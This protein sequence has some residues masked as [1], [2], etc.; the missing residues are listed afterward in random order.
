MD[1]GRIIYIVIFLFAFGFFAYNLYRLFALLCLGRFENRF[2]RLTDRFANMAA[3][4]F[5]QL[6]VM[7]TAYGV[8]HSLIFW[9]FLT[10]LLMN[11]EFLIGGVFP[12]F[13]FS[14]IGHIPYGVL[15]TMTGIMSLVVVISV[16]VAVV[17]RT[18]F[19][20]A[21][22]DPTF[23]AYFILGMIAALMIAYFGYHAGEIRLGATEWASWM[24]VSGVVAVLY[25]G[26]SDG[27]AHFVTQLCWWIHAIVLLVFMNYL[28][29]S[30]HLHVLT[31]IPNCFFRSFSFVKTVPR[32]VFERG[33]S[34]GHSKITQFTWKDLLDFMA[35]TECGRCQAACPAQVTEKELNP[36]QII[37][38]GKYNLFANGAEVMSK[39]RFDTLA[40]APACAEM[41]VGLIGGSKHDSVSE[42]ALWACTTCGACMAEC[43]VFIEHVPKIIEMRRSLVM[44][45]A[46]FPDEM[47]TFFE[48][49]E[50]RFN[51][52]GVA[53][54]D[55][56]KWTQDLDVPLVQDLVEQGKEVEY[57][58]YVGCSGSYDSRAKSIV[59]A[60]THILNASGVTWGILGK[61]EKCCG[62]SLRR[63]GNEY[64]FENLAVDNIELFN[65]YNIKRI[66]TCC[67]HGYNTLKNDYAQYC[68]NY[69]VFHHTELINQFIQQGKIKL[70]NKVNGRIVV[71][72][73][74]YL[75]RYNEIYEAPRN[76]LNCASGCAP[77]EMERNHDK[78]FC[79]GAGGGRMWLEELEGNRIHLERTKE[80]LKTN[81]TTIAVS[82]PFCMTMFE[83][84]VKDEN[85]EDKV[86]V[87]D[88]AEIVYEAMDHPE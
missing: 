52:W 57:L 45:Q 16:I 53:P 78:S 50:Q 30:K 5:G 84:G 72:D 44:E 41:K 81:P 55:R 38:Q 25:S 12:Q 24:P 60:M 1:A 9:G 58:F 28:P 40:P 66:V 76:I 8:N 20:P 31:A 17:R 82:C 18:F 59:T 64:L 83:D 70:T 4:A 22:I 27:A 69:E 75:G 46:K 29:Y 65:K 14:F 35:C 7:K 3:F 11:T 73:S 87:K 34:F 67:P 61:E 15:L 74:C 79:C 56:T 36:K 42:N 77:M 54:T 49:S 39:R 32:L 80:A 43:P 71:H 21:H 13:S 48:N 10:L 86:K 37:H 68:T 26:M 23:D 62:D 51:P 6:R 88:I 47:L 63:L 2:D 33:E 19:R 85:V